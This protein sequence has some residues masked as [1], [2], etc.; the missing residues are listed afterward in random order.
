MEDILNLYEQPY[1]FN[2][3][4]ICFDERPCQLID[5]VLAPLPMAEGQPKREDYHYQRNGT[6]KKQRTP[7]AYRNV[8]IAFQPHTGQ[9]IVAVYEKKTH[10]E[11]AD[12]FQ[13]ISQ[14]YPDASQITVVQDNLS[15]HSPA[16]FY[17]V[18]KPSE[19]FALTDKFK[20]HYTPVNASWLNIAEIELSAM[21]KQCLDRRIG[22]METLE[23]EVEAWASQRNQK[24]IKVKWQFTNDKARE[25]F[26]R[27]YPNS[28]MSH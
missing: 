4:L 2:N 24:A 1:D 10:K 22:C 18:F 25:K 14:H 9:R 27:F 5:D 6:C 13:K 17:K 20:M 21:S 11:Y 15:T 12:F 16:S 7:S 8:F 23:R 28:P 19:A 26:S 3:P